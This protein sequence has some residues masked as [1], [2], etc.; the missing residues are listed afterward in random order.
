MALHIRWPPLDMSNCSVWNEQD[1]VK[2]ASATTPPREN[3]NSREKARGTITANSRHIPQYFLFVA[4]IN[5]LIKGFILFRLRCHRRHRGK[6][7]QKL[8][9]GTVED[10]CLLA[11]LQPK[12]VCPGMAASTVD[13]AF[14]Y[15]LKIKRISYRQCQTELV[16]TICPR[17]VYFPGDPRLVSASPTDIRT[18][19][20]RS[21]VF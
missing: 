5:T 2:H 17:S 16:K 7:G 11:L 14:L 15:A 1:R 4:G 8:N 6:P 12:T 3:G 10:G 18:Q 19:I 21:S 9:A 13:R 20:L